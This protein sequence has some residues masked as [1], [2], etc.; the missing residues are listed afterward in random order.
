MTTAFANLVAASLKSEKFT[1]IDIGCSGGLEPAWRL[2]GDRFRA[3][4]FDAS[5]EECRRLAAEEKHPDVHYVAGFVG[6]QPDHPFAARSKGVA[7]LTRNVFPRTSARRMME[8]RQERLKAA[9]LEERLQ[10]NAWQITELAD[11]A[12]P[13]IVPETL[14]QLGFDDVDL[15]KIDID[16]YDF[17]VLHSF[18][19]RFDALSLLAARLEVNLFGGPE[20]TTHTFHNTDRFMR[21]RGFDLAALDSR[22]YSMKALPSRFAITMPAQTETGRVFQADAYY[23]RDVASVEFAGVA[24]ALSDEKLAKLAAVLSVWRQPDG[25][26]EILLAFRTRLASLLDIDAA[27]DLLAAQAQ[28]GNEQPLSYRN[29]MARFEADSADFYPR[30]WTPPPP[31]TLKR[32]IAAALRAFRDPNKPPNV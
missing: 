22:S 13:V 5:V 11:A 31:I 21:Q 20:D 10:H 17:V 26:A 14:R 7:P 19:G 9:A 15:L 1:L 23:L 32:R 3:I 12:R 25:A 4:G 8:L 28:P 18:D 6:L 30:P 27:L 2:F 29:Y 24:A 16:S